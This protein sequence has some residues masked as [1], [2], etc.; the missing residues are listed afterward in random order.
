MWLLNHN[1]SVIKNASITNNDNFNQIFIFNWKIKQDQQSE[2]NMKELWKIPNRQYELSTTI[3][4]NIEG[5]INNLIGFNDAKP[6]S[7]L[8]NE[9]KKKN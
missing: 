4:Q 2:Q 8:Q 5:E 3:H 1:A 9:R 6:K 7:N